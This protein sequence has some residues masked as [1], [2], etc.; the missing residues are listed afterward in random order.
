MTKL[1]LGSLNTD[2]SLPPGETDFAAEGKC[3]IREGKPNQ[4]STTISLYSGSPSLVSLGLAAT[5][6]VSPSRG[7]TSQMLKFL[8]KNSDWGLIS[9]NKGVNECRT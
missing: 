6:P 7:E 5:K 9:S 3:K 4:P 1:F 8:P 2:P